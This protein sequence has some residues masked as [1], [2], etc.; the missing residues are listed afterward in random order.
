MGLKV[1]THGIV[2]GVKNFEACVTFYR[3]VIGLPVWFEKKGL[4]CL[5]FGDAYLMVETKETAYDFMASGDGNRTMLRFNVEDVQT[6]AG[7]LRAQGVMVDVRI[8]EWGT[9]GTFADPDG[10]PCELKNADD[11]D[12]LK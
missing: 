6:S 4:V 2:L 7:Q 3:D 10:N 8:H 12:F 11:G 9:V 5:R 1:K